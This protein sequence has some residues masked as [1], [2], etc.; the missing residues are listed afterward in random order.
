MKWTERI[1]APLVIGTILV[2]LIGLGVWQIMH[3]VR[4]DETFEVHYPYWCSTCKAVY[5]VEELKVDPPNTW[6]VFDGAGSDSVVVCIRCDKGPAYPAIP[7]RKCKTLYLLHLVPDTQCP[8]C[9]PDAAA[10]ATKAGKYLTP[11]EIKD[12]TR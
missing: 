8:T 6:R 4:D 1:P 7:C 10:R 3:Q 2:A 12:Y 9:H 5:D 11:P